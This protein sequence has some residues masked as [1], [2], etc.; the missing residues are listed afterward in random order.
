MVTDKSGPNISTHLYAPLLSIGENNIYQRSITDGLWAIL[1]RAYLIASNNKGR[2]IDE[3]RHLLLPIK[4]RPYGNRPITFVIYHVPFDHAE[5]K[6]I[7]SF[8]V[9][10]IDHSKVNHLELLRW[11]IKAIQ[12]KVPTAEIVVCTDKQ[13]A[14]QLRDLNPSILI[15]QVERRRPMYYRARTYNSIIQQGWIDGHVVFLDSDAIVLKDISELLSQFDF[16]IAVTARFAPNLMPINE[17]V[18]IADARSHECSRFFAHYMGTYESIRSDAVIK[19]ITKNDL[20][21]WRGGQLSLN[22]IC[23]GIKMVDWRDSDE[24]LKILPCRKY[25]LAV[26]SIKEVPLLEKEN[27]VYIAHIKG[28]AKYILQ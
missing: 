17:G 9:P 19:S 20:M 16:K 10:K 22:A 2:L 27:S 3:G 26:K 6:S 21:R 13:L 12:A 7:A 4:G 23:P 25:N 18:I 28:R 15:P 8:D 24:V 1:G 11:T 5:D 14:A